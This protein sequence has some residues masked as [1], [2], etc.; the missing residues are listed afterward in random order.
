MNIK[1]ILSNIS[2]SARDHVQ[3]PSGYGVDYTLATVAQQFA[4]KDLSG[5]EL[6]SKVK[7][8]LAE[9]G[10]FTDKSVES[11]TKKVLNLISKARKAASL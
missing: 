1:D 5:A 8:R 6:E 10:K 3:V 4:D 2:D 7:E 9:T 11:S